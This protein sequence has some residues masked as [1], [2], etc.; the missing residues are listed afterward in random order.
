LALF[1][2]VLLSVS[3]STLQKHLVRRH[4]RSA[5]LWRVTYTW[6]AVPSVVLIA[7]AVTQRSTAGFWINAVIAGVLD[8]L[9]NLAM[10][11]ALRRTD[12]SIFGPL[13]GFRPVLALVFAWIFL[14]ERPS[15]LGVAGVLI[16]VIGAGLLL[17]DEKPPDEATRAEKWS[18]LGLRVL[19][20]ALSTFAAVFLKRA[21]LAGGTGMTLGVWVLCG[22]PVFWLWARARDGAVDPRPENERRFLLVH[23]LVFFLMQWLTLEVFRSTLLAY[24]FA[25]FQLAMVLQVF[26][27]RWLF[28]EKQ[29]GR[30]LVCCGIIGLGAGLITIAN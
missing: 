17:R 30:R 21:A 27:G 4:V 6:M 28:E 1:G 25:F 29:F 15:G 13:N 10:V 3:A 24:S 16:T 9:G 5:L 11:A 22:L 20:L 23:A 12:L 18:M 2:R 14:S 26:I 7:L 19:G 8:A